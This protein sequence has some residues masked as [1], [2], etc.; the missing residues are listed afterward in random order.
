MGGWGRGHAGGACDRPGGRL[1]SRLNVDS[2]TTLH[3]AFDLISHNLEK[4]RT[5]ASVWPAPW[6][7]RR[8]GHDAE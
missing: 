3:G 6:P 1:R 5:K 4:I 8:R 7:R 2:K